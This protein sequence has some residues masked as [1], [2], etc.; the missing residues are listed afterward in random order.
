MDYS[1]EWAR[2]WPPLM[3]TFAAASRVAGAGD[4]AE[5]MVGQDKYGRLAC[6][7]RTTS[8]ATSSN[9]WARITAWS[10]MRS[11]M[12]P[13]WRSWASIRWGFL[14]IADIVESQVWRVARRRAHRGGAHTVRFQGSRRLEEC[15][16]GLSA[17]ENVVDNAILGSCI[18]MTAYITATGRYLPGDPVTNDEI[19]DYIGKAGR[20]VLGSEGPDPGQLRN[21]DAPLRN[22]QESANRHLECGD[23]GRRGAQRRRA[24]RSGPPRGRTADGGDHDARRVWSR[25]RQHGARRA[26][27]W[28]AGDCHRTRHLQFRD[29]GAEERLPAGG[30]R[31]E[32]QRDHRRQRVRLPRVQEHPLRRDAG[33]SPKTG[34]CRWKPPFCATCSPTARAPRCSRTHP[35][36]RGSAF[37]STGSR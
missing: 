35:R 36:H 37:A 19:E 11:P 31:R 27:L 20:G 15:R 26:G 32:A 33:R 8:S 24:C 7:L 10:P 2:R 16:S 18:G 23:G 30:D 12:N 34:R 28:P 1:C 13:R 17:S 25:A 9:F 6:R 3:E 4:P 22:R 21:Q 29:D 5:Q 14:G